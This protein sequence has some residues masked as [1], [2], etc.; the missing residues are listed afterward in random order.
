MLIMLHSLHS[1]GLNKLSEH[2]NIG[3]LIMKHNVN[4]NLKVTKQLSFTEGLR[5]L[6][7]SLNSD[8]QYER[9]TARLL[10]HLKLQ[11]RL[12]DEKVK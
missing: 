1:V 10:L 8:F 4:S 11:E 9:E 12:K 3:G 7:K 6:D 5:L 2:Y